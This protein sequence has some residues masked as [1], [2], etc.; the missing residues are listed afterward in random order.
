MPRTATPSVEIGLKKISESSLDVL[1]TGDV[2]MH[3]L[4]E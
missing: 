2:G 3:V 4:P 1:G